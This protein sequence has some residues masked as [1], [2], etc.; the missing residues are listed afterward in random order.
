M[1]EQVRVVWSAD[2]RM[3][4][5][6]VY[7]Y[8]AKSSVQNATKVR[9]DIINATRKIPL[10]PYLHTPDKYKV[11]NDGTY[12]AFEKHRYRIAY[13]V[14]EKEIRILRVRHTSME[15]EGY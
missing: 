11:D 3:Q 4:L 14:F 2:A 10:N 6:E 8:I 13:R 12:R 5:K 9:S 1:V 15:P 7:K